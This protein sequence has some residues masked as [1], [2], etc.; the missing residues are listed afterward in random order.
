M[1]VTANIA[2]IS[3]ERANYSSELQPLSTNKISL[4]LREKAFNFP[5]IFSLSMS[6]K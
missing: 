4:V 6:F 2:I 3:E 1:K 5:L